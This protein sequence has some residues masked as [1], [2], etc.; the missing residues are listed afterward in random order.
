[1]G[2]FC[3]GIAP[4]DFVSVEIELKDWLYGT[5]VGLKMCY[6]PEVCIVVLLGSRFLMRVGWVSL[7]S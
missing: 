7:S 1:M 6:R 5:G 2:K 4:T 3:I